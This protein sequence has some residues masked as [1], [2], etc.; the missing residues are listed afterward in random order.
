MEKSSNIKVGIVGCGAV[1]Q[2]YYAKVLPLIQRVEIVKVTDS[3]LE[4]AKK[5]FLAISSG[6]GGA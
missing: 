5:G 2:S 1:V 3:N 4:S 6:K